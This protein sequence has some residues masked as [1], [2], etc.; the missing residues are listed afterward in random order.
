M[1]RLVMVKEFEIQL[2]E[3]QKNSYKEDQEK[4]SLKR[5]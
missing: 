4:N 2:R 5:E 3:S 1:D